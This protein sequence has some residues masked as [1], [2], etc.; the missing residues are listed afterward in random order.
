MGD[1][2]K[3]DTKYKRCLLLS[4]F[5]FSL[6][7]ISCFR[8]VATPLYA[9]ESTP[10]EKVLTILNDVAGYDL[11]KYMT[12]RNEH[13]N[14]SYFDVIPQENVGYTFESENSKLKLLCTF[15]DGNLHILHVLEREGTPYMTNPVTNVFEMAKGFLNNY[16]NY[17]GNTFYGGLGSMLDNVEMNKNVSLTSGNIKLEV[18]N[19][20]DHN[21]FTWSYTINAIES[22]AKCVSLSYKNGFLKYFIDT[23]NLYKIGNTNVN[24]SKE[25]AIDIAMEQA[26]EFSWKIVIGN[27]TVEIN[28]FNVTEAV[29]TQLSFC[30]SRNADTVRDQNIFTLYPMWRIGIG[31]DKHYPGNVYGIYVDIWADTKEVRNVQEVFSTLVL[32]TDKIVATNESV[33]PLSSEVSVVDKHIKSTSKCT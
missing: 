18:T 19:T 8:S 22:K 10:Q 2:N 33:V 11:T 25:E 4:V 29:V 30:T 26:M 5:L 1:Q 16:Q 27:D 12:T 31:L 32:P 20:E 28:R 13:S 6:L 21:T 9:T 7:G 23:W 14:N 3:N 24:L 17:S 15:T